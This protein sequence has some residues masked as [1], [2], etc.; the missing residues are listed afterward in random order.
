[1]QQAACPLVCL[2]A[3]TRLTCSVCYHANM[4]SIAE[5][6]IVARPTGARIRT[7]L[8]LS[9]W[10]EAVVRMV[11]GHLGRLAGQD[12]AARCRLRVGD[13][14]RAARK[15]ALTPASSSRWAGAI[16][17]TSNDQRERAFKNL[18]DA[19]IGLRR[20]ARRLRARL[21]VPTGARRGRTQGYA[22]RAE[23]F[24]KQRRLQHVEAKLAEVEERITKGRV[25]VCRGGRRLAKLQH[26]SNP[27]DTALTVAEWR[28]R[29]EAE[30]LFLTA[31]GEADV[32]WGNETIR[33]HPHERWLEIRLPTPLAHLSNTPGRAPTYRL[34][35][36]VTFT[37]RD[38]EWAA[39]ASSGA[40][41]YDIFLD[42]TKGKGTGRWYA[43][44][45]WR[46]P[47]RPA[48]SLDEL[49][50]HRSLAVDLNA[51]HL[52]A[53]VLNPAGNP[54]EEPV[55]IPLHLDG[56]PA[57][58]RDGR[59]R[60]AVAELLRLAKSHGCHS[61]TVENLDFADARQTG[62]E[63]LGR[64]KH[65]KRF[66]NTVSG[67][68]IR[69]FRDLLVGMATNHGLW[70]IAVEPAWTS[71]WGG[72]YWQVPLNQSTRTSVAVSRHHAAA[73]VIGRRGLGHRARRRG[74]CAPTPPADGEGKAADSAGR[75]MAPDVALAASE[76]VPKSTAEGPSGPGGQ[77]AGPPACKTCA[78]ERSA[79]G[80]QAAQDRS[81]PPKGASNHSH[82]YE[83]RSQP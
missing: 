70:I 19:R 44:A 77:R 56:Q 60:Q 50:Q 75:P 71:V 45:S 61:V 15:R 64:G 3:L 29:W 16:T 9:A 69:R 24:Q 49:R 46:L 7:R 42:L 48:P 32:P 74:G 26:T 62:R 37:H 18:L 66:R 31:D 12:L 53:W 5:P 28:A 43:D 10:D 27:D 14:Q 58:T 80:D 47:A 81:V 11:G 6:F 40:V 2:E 54:L 67:M 4:R 1:V 33:I 73:V 68:P 25:S 72:R 39:Q 79:D 78:P 22:S 57:S 38:A 59:L 34:S 13:D 30:R 82:P 63:T 51:D 76:V 21:A 23:R 8:R 36:S 52:A 65:G 20:A 55:T 35:C 17:R 83:E 41:R